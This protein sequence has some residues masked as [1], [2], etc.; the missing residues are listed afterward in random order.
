[1]KAV[2]KLVVLASVSL[3]PMLVAHPSNLEQ[4]YLESCRKDPGVPVPIHVV[5]PTVGAEHNGSSVQLE[6]VVDVQGRPS[7]FSIK[8]N[9]DDV[10]AT[11]VVEAVKQ[12]RFLPAQL[13]GVPIAT[14]VALPVRI[15]DSAPVEDRYAVSR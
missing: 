9:S 1:M 15:V 5:S 10:L 4:E 6:F 2:R 3:L 7:E 14:K 13:D 11:K 8:S 12:W